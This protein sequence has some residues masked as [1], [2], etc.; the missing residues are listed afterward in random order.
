L[1]QEARSLALGK[2]REYPFRLL[3]G[4]KVTVWA[5][6]EDVRQQLVEIV[7][8][9]RADRI[10]LYEFAVVW[11]ELGAGKSH[12]LRYLKHL[13]SEERKEEFQSPVVYLNTLKLEDKSNFMSIYRATMSGM[14][15][16]FRRAGKALDSAVNRLVTEE[17]QQQET[18][19]N[20]LLQE[21][22]FRDRR[23]KQILDD[24]CAT[25]PALPHLL[26]AI[27][28]GNQT[29]LSILRGN[30]HKPDD[31][32]E[33]GLTNSI[34]NDYD[35]IRSLGQF[36]NLVT[37]PVVSGMAPIFKA[38]YLFIDELDAIV[39]FKPEQIISINQGLRDLLNACPEHFCLLCGFTG[40]VNQLEAFLESSVL[41]RL[42][43]QPIEI[44]PLDSD[45]SV[46]FLKQVLAYYHVGNG[47]PD[48][49]PFSEEALKEIADKTTTKTPR[50]LFK[51]ARIVLE[52]AVLAGRLTEDGVIGVDLV[53]EYLE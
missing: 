12:A 15:E 9:P 53:D 37:N 33:F 17:W 46:D 39:D 10:G 44:P 19:T 47:V 50:N 3:P 27:K 48:E 29:A 35:A 52:K 16:E 26:I 7:D 18:Q 45:Q 20:Q 11:G 34:E 5:G 25:F 28:N 21:G 43:R 51:N 30:K 8:S 1:T 41:A 38:V 40:D 14:E 22:E 42:S 24:L 13:I 32:R 2:F 31:L 36:V 49:Y 4:D 23:R 6:Y